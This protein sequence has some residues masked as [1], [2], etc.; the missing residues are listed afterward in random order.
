MLE[1]S[2]ACHNKG[3]TVVMQPFVWI[4][5]CC[6]LFAVASQVSFQA[7]L[8]CLGC[9]CLAAPMEMSAIRSS[10]C[11]LPQMACVS[12]RAILLCFA[13]AALHAGIVW[14][15]FHANC[16]YYLW[17]WAAALGY[18]ELD[19]P[20]QSRHMPSCGP[21]TQE[22]AGWRLCESWGLAQ[23]SLHLLHLHTPATQKTMHMSIEKTSKHT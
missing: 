3:I 10:V 23:G 5:N 13:L 18:T 6:W 2:N 14:S 11:T 17:S 21:Q 19:A 4:K 15:A 8:S 7:Q 20:L 12:V 22:T 1:L 9:L 16:I